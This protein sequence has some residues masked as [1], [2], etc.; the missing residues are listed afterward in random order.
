MNS[1]EISSLPFVYCDLNAAMTN[2]GYLLTNG[3]LA[4]LAKLG[5]SEE[6]AVGLEFRFGDGEL[7]FSGVI[8]YHP[9][10]GYLAYART[11]VVDWPSDMPLEL[12]HAG[13]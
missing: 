3:S 13:A 4:S 7:M 9:T 8:I 12:P 10:F 2:T 1:K 5:L 6:K 11:P